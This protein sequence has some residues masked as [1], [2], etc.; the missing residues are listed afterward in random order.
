[1]GPPLQKILNGFENNIRDTILEGGSIKSCNKIRSLP[2]SQRE[3]RGGLI[4]A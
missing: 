1:M 3:V 2:L 4:T